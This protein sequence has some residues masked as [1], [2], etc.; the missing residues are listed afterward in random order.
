M[1]PSLIILL[2]V[3]LMSSACV[4]KRVARTITFEV[5]TTG[6][7][8]ITSLSVRGDDDPLSWDQN[9]PL[10]DQD[11]DGIYTGQ[12][13]FTTPYKYTTIKFVKNENQFE[14]AGQDNRIIPLADASAR[15]YRCRYDVMTE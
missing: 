15:T 11:G 7:T 5:D 13:T 3:I 10:S 9:T 8:N 6:I 14:L 1:K 2:A 4:Q 12:V